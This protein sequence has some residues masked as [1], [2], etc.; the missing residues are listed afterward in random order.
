M[1]EL[2]GDDVSEVVFAGCSGQG[3]GGVPD[4]WWEC[5]V[6]SCYRGVKC[7]LNWTYRMLV[8]SGGVL[9]AVRIVVD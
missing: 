1:L 9:G 4:W 8:C 2:V 6:W 3:C 7:G 5:S